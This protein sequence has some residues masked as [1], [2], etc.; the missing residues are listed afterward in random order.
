MRNSAVIVVM[1]TV[2]SVGCGS[3]VAAPAD[4]FGSGTEGP[5]EGRG[6]YDY[7]AYPSTGLTDV[8]P[9]YALCV[10]ACAHIWAASC[11]TLSGDLVTDCPW[12]CGETNYS[13]EVCPAAC[14]DEIAEWFYCIIH[15]EIRCDE[16]GGG[17]EPPCAGGKSRFL[18]CVESFEASSCT[19]DSS[20]QHSCD[21]EYPPTTAYECLSPPPF[22]SGCEPLSGSTYCCP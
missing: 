1:L 15:S 5:G 21:Y 10:E 17:V 14:V 2:L 4:L 3:G 6:G 22:S 7:I 11:E 13:E 20:S 19:R 8:D 16:N 9:V 18:D 12:E